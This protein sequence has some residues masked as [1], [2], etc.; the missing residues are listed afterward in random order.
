MAAAKSHT[1]ALASE[2]LYYEALFN[3]AGVVRV[4]EISD[5]F[6]CASF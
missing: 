3:R 1:G 6:N 2:D 4:E 5:L